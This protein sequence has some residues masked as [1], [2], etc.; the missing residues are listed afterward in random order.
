MNNGDL[1]NGYGTPLE[2]KNNPEIND[3]EN[4]PIDL[5]ESRIEQ[6]FF[7]PIL[8][9]KNSDNH[10]TK[11][12]NIIYA[13]P[14]SSGIQFKYRNKRTMGLGD[15]LK[16]TDSKSKFVISVTRTSTQ[17]EIERIIHELKKHNINIEYI[18]IPGIKD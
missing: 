13:T 2:M 18:T 4:I 11:H 17:S 5:K 9:P 1:V 3:N 7:N 14:L 12:A 15:I 10:T 16:N 6:V 8:F